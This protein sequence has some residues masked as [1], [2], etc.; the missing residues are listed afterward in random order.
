MKKLM[1]VAYFAALA[2]ACAKKSPP[3]KAAPDYESVRQHAEQSHE[4]LKQEESK[5]H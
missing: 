2:V 4:S 5:E 1:L 3:P